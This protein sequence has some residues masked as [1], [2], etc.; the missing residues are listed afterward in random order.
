MFAIG[1]GDETVRLDLSCTGLVYG[2]GT[3]A[4]GELYAL[5]IGAGIS[6]LVSA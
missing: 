5:T 3:D 4:A 1:A 6:K 2:F